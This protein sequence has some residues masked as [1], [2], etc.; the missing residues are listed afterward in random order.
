MT[1]E[2]SEKCTRFVPSDAVHRVRGPHTS[3]RIVLEV[4][5]SAESLLSGGSPEGF[6]AGLQG[7]LVAAA[8][9]AARATL[10]RRT[11]VR[12]ARGAAAGSWD[13]EFIFIEPMMTREWPA[14]KPSLRE[15]LKQPSSYRRTGYYPTVYTVDFDEQTDEYVVAL[16]GL[17]MREAS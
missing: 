10:G 7:A 6:V 13:G 11:R 17:T 15:V 12:G 9:V 3:T 2:R 1:P 8:V 5:L 16:S 14:T 4:F